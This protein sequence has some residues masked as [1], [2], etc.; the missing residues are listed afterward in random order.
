MW[1]SVDKWISLA[2]G[3]QYSY[4][5]WHEEDVMATKGQIGIFEAESVLTKL[6]QVG[7]VELPCRVTNRSR[8][9]DEWLVF[10]AVP[11]PEGEPQRIL[12]TSKEN[13]RIMSGDPDSDE[14]A[15]GQLHAPIA[16][17]AT[18]RARAR[19][20]AVL[21]AGLPGDP[22]TGG[23]WIGVPIDFVTREYI[24]T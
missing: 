24:T 22:Y 14:G 1:I 9:K 19:N 15:I 3:D 18:K 7:F 5:E 6:F 8:W 10:L 13:V 23:H 20:E 17:E 21:F 11:V 16:V 2:V 4:D 12:Y